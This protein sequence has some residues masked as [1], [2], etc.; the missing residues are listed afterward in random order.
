M[1]RDGSFTWQAGQNRRAIVAVCCPSCGAHSTK[2]IAATARRGRLRYMKCNACDHTWKE[3]ADDG[4]AQ[5]WLVSC[6]G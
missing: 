3:V 6:N 5:G 2:H 4:M 1:M